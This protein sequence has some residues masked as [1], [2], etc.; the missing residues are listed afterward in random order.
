M[1]HGQ[2]W[3]DAI[4]ATVFVVSMVAIWIMLLS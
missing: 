1:A 3:M 2:F 4:L